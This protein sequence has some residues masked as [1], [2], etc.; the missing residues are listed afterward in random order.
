[1]V[2]ITVKIERTT[3]GR[4]MDR[5]LKF[6][7]KGLAGQLRN[8]MPA[9]AHF[10]EER[11]K[12]LA[13]KDTSF[14]Q[15]N[16]TV[17]YAG[18]S[19]PTQNQMIVSWGKAAYG[20]AQEFGFRPHTIPIEYIEQH[21]EVPGVEGKFVQNPRAFVTVSKHTPHVIPAIEQARNE[22]ASAGVRA[23]RKYFR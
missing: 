3:R 13:P 9:V 10:I 5:K 19:S 7:K 4:K 6:L 23:V 12:Q 16:L 11:A 21:K 22:I 2:G 17:K 1:M 8:E 14:L 18:M 20:A 15:R